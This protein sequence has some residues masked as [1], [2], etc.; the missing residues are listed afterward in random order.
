[1]K[2]KAKIVPP[3]NFQLLVSNREKTPVIQGISART[4]WYLLVLL[5]GVC[6]T[7]GCLWAMFYTDQSERVASTLGMGRV[8]NSMDN[9]LQLL[10]F[11][12]LMFT[13]I[14]SVYAVQRLYRQY[15]LGSSPQFNRRH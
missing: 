1:M 2:R 5:L 12:V 10:A 4:K 13:V 14:V 7:L 3:E 15:K 6:G 9:I 8:A 11:P